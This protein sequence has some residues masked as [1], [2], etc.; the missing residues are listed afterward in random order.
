MPFRINNIAD[1]IPFQEYKMLAGILDEALYTDIAKVLDDWFDEALTELEFFSSGSTGQSKSIRHSKESIRQAISYSSK[2]LNYGRGTR[3]LLSLPVKYVAGSMILLRA[4]IL[5]MELCVDEISGNPLNGINYNIDFLALTP[6]QF[7]QCFNF[8]FNKL[9][10]VGTILLGG[11]PVPASLYSNFKDWGGKIY[12]SYGMTETLTQT[13]F[14]RLTTQE[15][16]SQ[17]SPIKTMKKVKNPCPSEWWACS[18]S[19]FNLNGIA[20]KQNSA[21]RKAFCKPLFS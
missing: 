21:S 12:Q 7:N 3:S 13:S 15:G 18:V 10:E 8:N 5:E 9:K 20:V 6:F 19:Y 4:V 14:L 16:R 11:A 17:E 1:L 2:R